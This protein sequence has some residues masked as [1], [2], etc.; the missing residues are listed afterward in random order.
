M[1]REEE[2]KAQLVVQLLCANR[3]SLAGI[4]LQAG[5]RFEDE[6]DSASR[7]ADRILENVQIKK[8]VPPY[9]ERTVDT[10]GPS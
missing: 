4:L 9:P 5:P 2:L 7:L 8:T 3:S 1:T 6:V 10:G